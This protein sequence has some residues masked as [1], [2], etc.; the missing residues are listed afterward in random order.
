MTFD[1]LIRGGTILDGV[2][3]D[4]R[5]ADIGITKGQIKVIGNLRTAQARVVIEA[6]NKYVSPGF[7]DVQSHSDSYLTLL[8]IPLQE[9]L[10]TQGITTIVVGQCGTSLAPLASPEALK[11]VQKWSSLSG[12]NLNWLTFG[13]YCDALARYPLGVNVLSLTGH[14]TL[15]RGLLRDEIRPATGEE[16]NIMSKML[17]DSLDAGAAGMSM[18][19][20]YAHE[21]DASS[22]ELQQTARLVA[23]RNKLLS[24]HLRSEGAHIVDALNEVVGLAERAGARLKIS[25][26]KIH[27]KQNWQFFEQALNVIDRAYQKGIDIFFDVYPYATSWTVLY[28]YLPKWAYEGGRAAILQNLKNPG[29]RDRIL[30]YLR[31]Q[32]LN[33]G[34]IFVATSEKTAS[35]FVGKTLAQIAVNQ[36]ISVEEAL[37]NV[38]SAT[39]TQVIVFDQ[40]LSSEL[41]DTLLKHPLSVVASDGAGYDLAYSSVHGLVHPRCFGTMP[42]FLSMVRD[43]KLMDW[44]AAIKK[45]TSRPAE[46]LGLKGLGKLQE[47][48]IADLVVFDPRAVGSRASYENPYQQADGIDWV[49]LNGKVG[50]NGRDLR[51]SAAGR[52]IKL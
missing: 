16:V 42:K 26:F 51:M 8:D 30:A 35:A 1:L 7:I 12:A 33:L 36:E 6:L 9:S 31:D 17:S 14:S 38:L 46:K 43:R 23:Q 10:L 24:V 13:E 4:G 39:Q 32:D 49:I 50:Y 45:I 29:S 47:G 28:T 11:S 18:G 52:V 22:E 2:A 27:G 25:H 44:A 20:I 3:N 34:T 5:L 37:L 21:V 40:N 15:R 41:V 19:L 48:A